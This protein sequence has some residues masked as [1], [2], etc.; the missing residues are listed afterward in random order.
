MLHP[1]Y[2]SLSGRSL[3]KWPPGRPETGHPADALTLG[4]TYS[5]VPGRGRIPF[6]ID[7][8]SGLPHYWPRFSSS[9]LARPLH[10][11]G[12]PMGQGPPS[13]RSGLR[14]LGVFARVPTLELGPRHRRGE[15]RLGPSLREDHPSRSGSMPQS[16]FRWRFE[17]GRLYCKPLSGVTLRRASISPQTT[18]GACACGPLSHRRSRQHALHPS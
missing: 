11:P 7:F 12:P 4:T 18:A 8:A 13:F 2:V 10:C 1:E 15:I 17:L 3:H 6:P 14:L 16:R 5:S 9:Y